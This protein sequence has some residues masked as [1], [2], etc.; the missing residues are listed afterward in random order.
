MKIPSKNE[1]C[2]CYFEDPR[3]NKVKR[4]IL[5]AHLEYFY[6][7]NAIN[8]KCDGDEVINICLLKGASFLTR[9]NEKLDV[10]QFDM[11]FIPNNEH[12]K[13]TPKS[14]NKLNNK[15]C[16][17]KSKIIENNDIEY[18]PEFEIK[19]FSLDNFQPRGEFGDSDKMATYREVWTA[20]KN[21]FYMSGFTN[22]P[23]NA[24][25]QGVVTSVNLEKEDGKVKI[26]PH[27]HPEYPEVY[28]YCIDDDSQSIAVSQYLINAKGNSVVK[29]LNDGDGVFFNGSM[30]HIN[31]A[32]PTYKNLEYCLYMWIIPTFGKKK[33]IKPVTLHI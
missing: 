25:S 22:I 30:G 27:I 1:M 32:K 18:K 3:Q 14:N 6:F 11:V 21:G 28:I 26:Y 19:H 4:K 29:D 17:V 24:L 13:I 20:F 7:S 12:I 31:F 15:I 10:N 33:D 5:N 2:S 23:N 8:I 16:I 9:D